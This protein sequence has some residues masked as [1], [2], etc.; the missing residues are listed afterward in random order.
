[1]VTYGRVQYDDDDDDD[2]LLDKDI[3]LGLVKWLRGFLLNRQARVRF[4]GMD[5]GSRNMR[6]GLPHGP[7]L[8]PV[9]FLFYI[10]ELARKLTNSNL[11]ALFGD[12][13][14]VLATRPS[15]AEAEAA[16]Q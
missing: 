12:D 8:S 3:Q 4:N 7:V 9:L 1:M 6:Q 16:T 13:A 15:P 2:I 14:S 11:N 5:S 10:N